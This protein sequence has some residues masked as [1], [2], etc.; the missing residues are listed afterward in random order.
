MKKL[1]ILVVVIALLVSV[2]PALAKVERVPAWELTVPQEID[3]TC[4]GGSYL[5]TLETVNNLPNGDSTGTGYYNPNHSYTWDFDGNINGD[6]F[7]FTIVYTGISA[8]SIYNGTGTIASDGS[9]SGSVDSNCQ[10]FSMGA[11]SA[12]RFEGNHGQWVKMS[13]N[14]KE[15]AQSRVGMPVQSKGHTK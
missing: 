5:H 7:T 1:A 11:G 9:I 4:G 8:G 13:E 2:V 10:F 15:A 12:V 14:K 6:D 3:F